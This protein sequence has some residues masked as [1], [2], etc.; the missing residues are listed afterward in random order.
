MFA[1]YHLQNFQK[2]S[3]WNWI[4]LHFKEDKQSEQFEN[5]KEALSNTITKIS[6]DIENV[7]HVLADKEIKILD[8]ISS[9]NESLKTKD[10]EIRDIITSAD[11]KNSASS[12]KILNEMENIRK[13]TGSK[14]YVRNMD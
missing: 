4:Y 3:K 11:E 5:V 8:K 6:S 13:R 7:E 12:K 2:E 9:T 14:Q 1:F 10:K